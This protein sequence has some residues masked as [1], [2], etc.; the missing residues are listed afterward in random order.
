MQK[1]AKTRVTLITEIAKL[2]DT[3]PEDWFLFYRAR[4]ALKIVADALSQRFNE[5]GEVLAPAFTCCTAI[6]PFISS[7]HKMR[8]IDIDSNSLGVNPDL[9]AL[10]K[11][12]RAILMQ[13]TFGLIDD[14]AYARVE[15]KIKDYFEQSRIGEKPIIIEDSAHCATFMAK[16][17]SGHY[18]ADVS[19]HSFGFLKLLNRS[20]YGAAM[21]VNPNMEDKTLYRT[22]ITDCATVANL[23]FYR[24][25]TTR[26]FRWQN[27][28][29][30]R[31]PQKISRVVR[32]FLADTGF[33]NAGI[34]R[35]EKLGIFPG[36]PRKP[37]VWIMKM[38]LNGLR[39]LSKNVKMRIMKQKRL[40]EE[41]DSIAEITIPTMVKN[42]IDQNPLLYFPL[43]LQNSGQVQDLLQI[44]N[45]NAIFASTLYNP[46]LFPG[47]LEA[48]K[49]Y[50]QNVEGLEATRKVETGILTIPLNIS[51]NQI[52]YVIETLKSYFK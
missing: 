40:C 15:T 27:R 51:E 10:S 30:T 39:D 9:V 6:T 8:Y 45:K 43:V 16:R 23:G 19:V 22:I 32:R 49:F 12:T 41:L 36:K 4:D 42:E 20:I 28:I 47:V 38:N 33:Y 29:Y 17:Q 18:F 48:K 3:N 2:T 25:F 13:N 24:R 31:L 21:W 50:L 7:G 26:T 1:T 5:T 46:L 11:K 34:Q 35:C 52:E 14:S 37:S 44:L